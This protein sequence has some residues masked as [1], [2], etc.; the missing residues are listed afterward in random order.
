MKTKAVLRAICLGV[1]TLVSVVES[2]AQQNDSIGDNR[3]LEE[4]TV[5]ARRAP[6]K[7][8]S[9]TPV[10]LLGKDEIKSLGLQ[11]M[12]DAVRR[13]AGTNVRDYGGIGGLKT[14]S[15]RNLGAAHTAVSYDGVVAA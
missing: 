14:V 3:Q 13:F 2:R 5:K 10:Q 8:T 7:V 12:A 9:A 11:N 6:V 4:V 15:V 1:F